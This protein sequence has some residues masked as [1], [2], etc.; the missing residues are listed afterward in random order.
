MSA[1]ASASNAI[2]RMQR[3]HRLFQHQHR[4]YQRNAKAELDHRSR[5]VGADRLGGAE[6]S[7]TSHHEMQ[8]AGERQQADRFAGKVRQDAEIAGG[9]RGDEEDRHADR[10]GDRK[11]LRH[12][13]G[14]NPAAR[15]GI[16]ERKRG[17]GQRGQHHSE[18][19]AVLRN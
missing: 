15:A 12:G 1:G 8:H 11:R 10:H 5:Q 3:G 9:K 13:T 7:I 4:Q 19:P 6:I 18:H 16:V 2:P 17:R 14:Q